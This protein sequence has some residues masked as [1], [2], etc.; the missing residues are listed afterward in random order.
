MIRMRSPAS[1]DTTKSTPKLARETNQDE[2]V[3]VVLVRGREGNSVEEAGRGLAE[4][5]AVLPQVRTTTCPADIVWLN[6]RYRLPRASRRESVARRLFGAG[7][8]KRE[9]V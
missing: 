8:S 9:P 7:G 6:R 4:R 2:S 3:G 5:D 1:A